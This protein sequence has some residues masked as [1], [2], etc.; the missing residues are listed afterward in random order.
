MTRVSFV[1]GRGFLC[2]LI[3]TG[4]YVIDRSLSRKDLPAIRKFRWA[5]IFNISPGKFSCCLHYSQ[6]VALVEPGTFLPDA[7]P[8]VYK[9]VVRTGRRLREMPKCKELM[10]NI[11]RSCVPTDTVFEAANIMKNHGVSAV[12]VLA[13]KQ[14]KELIGLVAERDIAVRVTGESLPAQTTVGEVMTPNVP[15]CGPDDDI[16]KALKL[17]SDLQIRHMP[18]VDEQGNLLGMINKDVAA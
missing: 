2:S 4:G 1:S 3:G 13:S 14:S 16:E 10:G 9:D 7:V 6:V 15:T 17:M 12:P 8:F 5:W 11:V 18:I